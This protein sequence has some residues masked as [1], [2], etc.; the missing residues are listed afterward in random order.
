[1]DKYKTIDKNLRKSKVSNK[2]AI[3]ARLS[4]EVSTVK[5]I[6]KVSHRAGVEAVGTGA[7]LAGGMSLARNVVAVARG[8]VEPEEAALEVVKDTGTGAVVS[9]T[10]AFMGSV[11]KGSM[12]NAG[13]AGSVVNSL[14]KTNLPVQIVSATIEAGKTL[15]KYFKGDIDGV[16]CLTELGE[17]GTGMVSSA[18]FAVIGQLVIPIP[19]VGGMIGGML[20]YVLSSACY[21]CLV[22]ALQ[23]AKIAREERL[24]IE[25]ECAEAV[26]MIREYRREMETAISRYLLEYMSTFQEALY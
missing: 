7:A 6:A 18:M 15:E 11:I 10:T 14:S 25:A 17:K 20:G 4:A 12:Q 21:R 24:R 19:V 16:E 26:K 1:L 8:E 22:S 5:D 9:C 13:K 3:E 2:E 23:G